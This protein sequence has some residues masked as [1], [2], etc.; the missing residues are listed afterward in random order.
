MV[1]FEAID[2]SRETKED[3]GAYFEFRRTGEGGG[4]STRDILP[5]QT[6]SDMASFST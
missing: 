4:V 2:K 5:L 3:S 6:G 1:K